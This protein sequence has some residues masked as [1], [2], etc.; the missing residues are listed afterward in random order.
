MKNKI[1]VFVL[2]L[3]PVFASSQKK[4]TL[5][6]GVGMLSERYSDRNLGSLDFRGSGYNL[7]LTIGHE[8]NPT[9]NIKGS[10]DMQTSELSHELSPITLTG[11]YT[12]I[13]LILYYKLLAKNQNAF[14]LGFGYT[15]LFESREVR[16][17]N[18]SQTNEILQ[19]LSISTEYKLDL[20]SL[21]LS[22]TA[23]IPVVSGVNTQAHVGNG[24][25]KLYTASFH[26]HLSILTQTH[27]FFRIASTQYIGLGYSWY[28]KNNEVAKTIN[29]AA[30]TLRV[31]YMVH[32]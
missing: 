13:G 23:V 6:F 3:L 29:K 24:E 12:A 19:G 30:H 4:N 16:G 17:T 2:I 7:G 26:N 32:L 22:L 21:L 10:F 5:S 11:S 1:L 8:F 27:V 15:G 9:L 18:L 14:S 25:H 20:G 28:L 31:G